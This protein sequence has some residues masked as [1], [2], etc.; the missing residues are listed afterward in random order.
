M[1]TNG[2]NK[3]AAT[4]ASGPKTTSTAT[5]QERG[6]ESTVAYVRQTAERSVDV[7]VGAVLTVAE[8]FNDIVEPWTSRTTA[9]RELKSLRT[10]VTREFNRLERKG[11]SARRKATQRARTTRNR[12]R[13]DVTQRRR[14]VERTLMQNRAQVARRVRQAQSTVSGRV[15]ALV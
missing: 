7:P 2:T 8:R 3:A 10:Q 1:P 15:G 4:K 12:V 14:N 6:P 11:T 5:K 13:R 9:E